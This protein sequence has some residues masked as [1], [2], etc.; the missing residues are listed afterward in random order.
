VQI[1][2]IGII[3]IRASASSRPQNNYGATSCDISYSAQHKS[4]KMYD[5]DGID[6]D[7]VSVRC[8]C[9]LSFHLPYLLCT[10]ILAI[11]VIFSHHHLSSS[12]ALPVG[13]RR[14][15]QAI[16]ADRKGAGANPEMQGF[17]IPH[18]HHMLRCVAFPCVTN[19]ASADRWAELK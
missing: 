7:W 19:S 15:L 11:P 17:R 4:V 14:H 9:N 8:I 6:K 18:G 5:S 1:P 13:F 2:K 16:P 12:S 3:A 10:F